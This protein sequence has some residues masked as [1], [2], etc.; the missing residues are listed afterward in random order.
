MI[1]INDE[2]DSEFPSK[3]WNDESKMWSMLIWPLTIVFFVIF[4]IPDLLHWVLI[5]ILNLFLNIFTYMEKRGR[6]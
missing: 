5:G 6:R 3:S 2:N 1:S 4:K